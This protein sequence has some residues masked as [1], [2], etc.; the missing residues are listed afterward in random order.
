MINDEVDVVQVLLGDEDF[1]AK[2]GIDFSDARYKDAATGKSALHFAAGN[3]RPDQKGRKLVR[4]LLQHISTLARHEK[5][6]QDTHFP[7]TVSFIKSAHELLVEEQ[8]QEELYKFEG[9]KARLDMQ[10][11]EGATPLHAAAAAG[12]PGCIES[13]LNHKDAADLVM[14]P[15]GQG[16]TA[17]RVAVDCFLGGEI[18]QSQISIDYM[19][20]HATQSSDKRVGADIL[21][22]K[23]DAKGITPLQAIWMALPTMKGDQIKKDADGTGPRLELTKLIRKLWEY[24]GVFSKDAKKAPQ[25]GSPFPLMSADTP[26]ADSA[27][28]S[29]TYAL[30][31][32]AKTDNKEVLKV[33]F[34][35]LG[36]GVD[37]EDVDAKTALHYACDGSALVAAKYLL[38]EIPDQNANP[39]K[40]DIYGH[41]PLYYARPPGDDA[42]DG[43]PQS[44]FV[45]LLLHLYN[46]DVMGR[47]ASA[48]GNAPLSSFDKKMDLLVPDARHDCLWHSMVQIDGCAYAIRKLMKEA[49]A[50]NKDRWLAF[51][52]N[53][54]GRSAIQLAADAKFGSQ[55]CL[56]ALKEKF[57]IRKRQEENIILRT[58]ALP[59][60]NLE[61]R[62]KKA[63][64]VVAFKELV[65]PAKRGEAAFHT[66]DGAEYDIATGATK[67]PL[68]RRRQALPPMAVIV[69]PR[70]RTDVETLKQ[71]IGMFSQGESD[72]HVTDFACLTEYVDSLRKLYT[73]ENI[74]QDH[75]KFFEG[76]EFK[77]HVSQL[78]KEDLYEAALLCQFCWEPVT[79]NGGS[80]P[81]KTSASDRTAAILPLAKASLAVAIKTNNANMVGPCLNLPL[82]H[83]EIP[84]KLL[85]WVWE[86]T[87]FAGPQDDFMEDARKQFTSSEFM[88]H[89]EEYDTLPLTA[90]RVPGESYAPVTDVTKD[91][92][93]N[94]WPEEP[95][96]AESKEYCWSNMTKWLAEVDPD[97][98]WGGMKRVRLDDENAI[99]VCDECYDFMK[100]NPRASYEEIRAKFGYKPTVA[101]VELPPVNYEPLKQM[102]LRKWIV[103]ENLD[104]RQK[105]IRET[106]EMR[107]KI[108]QNKAMLTEMNTLMGRMSANMDNMSV[109]TK[110]TMVRTTAMN[111]KQ[112]AFLQYFYNHGCTCCVDF[113]CCCTKTPKESMA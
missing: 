108:A 51:S 93:F 106:T 42:M 100:K 111:T 40:K 54:D 26:K 18:V 76:N 4:L 73:P 45:L 41:M 48:P 55:M 11:L 69:R 86:A 17:L 74:G 32:A 98:N 82:G 8:E 94:E 64:P 10:D 84:S 52:E 9:G 109:E 37:D 80:W 57:I 99:W 90:K 12:N 14:R 96:D 112:T 43:T 36:T 6:A 22:A 67:V 23:K 77:T 89:K 20:K 81:V 110:E 92:E 70:V 31:Q 13:L 56:T 2:S 107:E 101:T 35:D 65:L 46:K 5:K 33:L 66:T 28:Y 91:A 3:K 87:G 79:D 7:N 71:E 29:R 19:L 72:T 85:Q 63:N 88:A 105:I 103:S 34:E 68:E 53:A 60:A 61:D 15:D 104:L 38:A 39:C 62:A 59:E 83:N 27:K 50:N 102:Q 30:H 97:C 75:E 16:K 25:P 24:S 47:E 49:R 58:F 78:M 95:L 44:N 1:V 113:A 21:C